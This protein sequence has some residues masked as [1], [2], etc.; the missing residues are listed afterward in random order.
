MN[1]VAVLEEPLGDHKEQHVNQLLCHDYD[2]NP[3]GVRH[4]CSLAWDILH[5]LPTSELQVFSCL[6]SPRV[7]LYSVRY[8]HHLSQKFP[9]TVVAP[10]K[11][12][13]RRN[14]NCGDTGTGRRHFEDGLGGITATEGIEGN[15][16]PFVSVSLHL[17]AFSLCIIPLWISLLLQSALPAVLSY[18]FLRCQHVI[19]SSPP[20][21]FSQPAPSF[22]LP[23]SV[24]SVSPIPSSLQFFTPPLKSWVLSSAPPPHT[25]TS[26]KECCS[27]GGAG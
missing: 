3:K 11:I 17:G 26:L 18:P 19:H 8:S 14:L 5:F 16:G 21:V 15:H 4:F 23:L 6:S 1:L 9:K 20:L 22:C 7:W 12:K 10:V 27:Q 25:L 24:S 13:D 2:Y